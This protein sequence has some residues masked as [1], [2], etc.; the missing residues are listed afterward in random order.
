MS[1]QH[2]PGPWE[3]VKEDGDEWWF[4]G[5]GGRQI[6]IRAVGGKSWESFA[7]LGAEE[8]ETEADANARL[9]AAAPEL[10]E[11]LRSAVHLYTQYGLVSGAP[12]DGIS[13]GQWVNEARAAIAKA[14]GEQP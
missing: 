7:V 13:G 14:T 4:G 1:A 5:T 10:L 2:T 9:I 8:A 12:V 6:C 3:S 11:A